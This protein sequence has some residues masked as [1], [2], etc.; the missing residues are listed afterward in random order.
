MDS[1]AVQETTQ[2]SSQ[3][4]KLLRSPDPYPLSPLPPG[5]LPSDP[6]PP[7]SAYRRRSI[8]AAHHSGRPPHSIDDAIAVS[9]ISTGPVS[10]LVILQFLSLRL[11][12]P[13]SLIFLLFFGPFLSSPLLDALILTFRGRSPCC[14]TDSLPSP[15]SPSG[16]N[17]YPR[18]RSLTFLSRPNPKSS[19]RSPIS[20]LCTGLLNSPSSPNSL[21]LRICV[22][23]SATF[24]LFFF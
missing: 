11:P 4:V 5:F 3:L 12:F 18:W 24:S 21:P 10:S 20:A 19:C 9:R 6:R 1:R 8:S 2:D 17:H 7:G 13:F 14:W 23:G 15:T 22:V 16:P